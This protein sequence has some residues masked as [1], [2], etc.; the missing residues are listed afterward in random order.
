MWMAHGE[1]WTWMRIAIICHTAY[2]LYYSI[3]D[4][5]LDTLHC[6]GRQKL[7]LKATYICQMQILNEVGRFFWVFF[8]YFSLW[9]FRAFLS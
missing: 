6:K 8:A 2:S 4:Q 1:W 3:I 5:T 7:F 9:C